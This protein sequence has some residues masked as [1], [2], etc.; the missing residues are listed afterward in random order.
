MDKVRLEGL[1][2]RRRF[3]R[4]SLGAAGAAFVLT[5]SSRGAAAGLELPAALP[6]GYRSATL[7]A[8]EAWRAKRFGMF[9]HWGPV[10]I[11]GTEIG[12]SRGRE[13]PIDEYDQLPEQF[14]PERFDADAWISA[15]KDAGMRY[16]VITAK[17]HDGFCLWPSDFTDHDLTRTQYGGDVLEELAETCERHGIQLGFY[18]SILDWYHPDYPYGSPSGTVEKPNPDMD[19]Y[20]E[21]LHNQVRELIGRYNPRIM[22]F[23]GE[24]EDAWTAER[25]QDLYQMIKSMDPGILVNN[26]VGVGRQADGYAPE[27]HGDFATPEQRV[28][29]FN[30]G[31]AWESCITMCEQWAWKPDDA[32]K[33]LEE[34]L[35]ILISTAGGDGNLLF[36]VGPMPD[37]RIEPRQLDRLREMGQWMDEFGHAIYETRGGPWK[38][39]GAFASTC[40]DDHIFA[41]VFEGADERVALPQLDASITDIQALTPDAV[42]A[43]LQDER[44]EITR[45]AETERPA[46][47]KITVEGDATAIEPVGPD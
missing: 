6:E 46:I 37:G 7:D 9:V 11:R 35:R 10:S 30:R 3:L 20:V 31:R 14:N 17:H 15:A 29:R 47:V 45:S 2:T 33:S 42:D 5:A 28:G 43:H 12:W 34:C 27:T 24:W 41:F 38:P 19:A 39:G 40:K 44:V 25:G 18:Y 16:F 21:F 1:M 36:N 26:R 4:G 23:D 8:L 32:M 13:V 22:W